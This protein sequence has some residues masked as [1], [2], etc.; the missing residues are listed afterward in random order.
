MEQKNSKSPVRLSS[1]LST[2]KGSSSKILARD[3]QESLGKLPPQ[4][5]DLEEAILGAMLLER[6]AV[7]TAIDLLGPEDFYLESHKTIYEAILDLHRAS[8]P[9]D[10]RTVVSQLRKV[11]K[12]EL[13]EGAYK[14]AE[15]TSKVSSAANLE[16]H[17]RILIEHSIRRH[18]IR[19]SSSLQKDAFDDT[20]DV[21]EILAGLDTKIGEKISP[22]LKGKEITAKQLFIKTM[23][24]MQARTQNN[25]ITGIPSGYSML[26]KITAGWQKSELTIIAARPGMGKTAFIICCLLNAC[27]RFKKRGAIFSLEMSDVSLM[28][29]MI[30]S[31]SEIELERIRKNNVGE[32]GYGQII[33]RTASLASA[34][35]LVDETAA[36]SILE[37]RAKARRM[38]NEHDIEFIVVDY[39]QLMRG[40]KGGNREQEVSSISRALKQIAKDLEIPVI[41]LSQLGRGVEQRG[42]DKRPML[43]DLRESGSIEQDADNVMF[44][45]RPEYYGIEQDKDGNSMAGVMEVIIAKHRNGSLDNIPLKF[46]GKFTK[47]TDW[48]APTDRVEAPEGGLTSISKLTYRDPTESQPTDDL[49]F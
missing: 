18:L 21:F 16:Y 29:R 24:I 32:Q 47:I 27:I 5:I 6:N 13:V 10:M 14:V 28:D 15:L 23:G 35:F 20:V 1:V 49:P 40:E 34:P 48:S 22:Y 43:S 11:G 36:L 30:S 31:E 25:G 12:L 7:I 3:I 46:V 9:V 8:I 19:I 41:A 38:K 42:G 33:Q 45:Y 26:D 44:L 4:A 37:L 2:P 39:L 17:A